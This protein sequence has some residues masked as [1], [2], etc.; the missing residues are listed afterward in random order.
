MNR[1]KKMIA[2]ALRSLPKRPKRREEN[3]TLR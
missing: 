3:G 2:S 1:M